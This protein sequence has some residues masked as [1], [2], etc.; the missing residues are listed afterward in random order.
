MRRE[1]ATFRTLRRRLLARASALAMRVALRPRGWASGLL[2]V[3]LIGAHAPALAQETIDLAS[4]ADL[5]IQGA[6]AGDGS[7]V[8]VSGAGDVNGDGIDD[9]IIG[10][11]C[12]DPNGRHYAGASYVVFGTDQG[13]P[14]TIDLASDA[15]LII[16]GAAAYDFSGCSVSGAG[17]VD[18]DGIDDLII[19][20]IRADPNGRDDA[21]ASYVVFGSDETSRRATIDLADPAN[22]ADLIIQ[23]AAAYDHSGGSV[24]GAGDVNGDGIDDLIIGARGADPNGRVYAG[25]SYVVFGSDQGF[26]ATIDLASD[27]DLIIQGAAALDFS[28]YSVSGAGDVDG[29][30]IDDLII[31]APC[32][33][34]NGRYQC[35][36]QLRGVRHRSRL[37]RDHRPR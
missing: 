26:P 21:G 5:T 14:A 17:D 8:S 34:P 19:G 2:A 27:A 37:P 35:R 20:A 30:G 29:D 9:L 13:F 16:Q 31:G 3:G 1:R 36:R 28:G 24:S 6:A 12:A 15:D 10:A 22:G 32:A 25:A 7:G 11:H 4:D 33:D 18:G 23:G